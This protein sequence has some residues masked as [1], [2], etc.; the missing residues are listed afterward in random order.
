MKVARTHAELDAALGDFRRAGQTIG[1]VPT[2]GALHE[3][4]LSL[5]RI[6]K[7][8]A[9]IVV[10]SLFVNPLQFSDPEDLASYPRDDERDLDLAS[11]KGCD[12]V[13]QPPLTE[14]YPQGTAVMVSVGPPLTEILEGSARPGHFDGVATVVA[15]L[16][17]A[18]RPDVVFFGQKDA[19]QVAVIRQLIAGLSY[20]IKLVVCP[21]VRDPDGLALSSRNERLSADDR[22]AARSLYRALQDGERVLAGGGDIEIAEKEMRATLSSTQGVLPDYAR[23]VDPDTFLSPTGD[24]ILLVVAAHVGPVRLID[25]KLIELA[26]PGGG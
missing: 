25:N 22:M 10:L 1:L 9:D 26:G 4:H 3:G 7:K 16:F 13:F 18:A 17:N 23:A 5:I 20:P 2:M 19:Q 8:R 15:K 14:M 24:R 21:T 6:A 11:S 12:V